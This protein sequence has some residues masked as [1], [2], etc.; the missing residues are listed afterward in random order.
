[1]VFSEIANDNS[2][3]QVIISGDKES[4]DNFNLLIKKE[5]IKSIPLKVSAPFHCSLMKKAAIK[6]EEKLITQYLKTLQ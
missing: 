6:M 2:D 5:R 4:I 1:M 3:G